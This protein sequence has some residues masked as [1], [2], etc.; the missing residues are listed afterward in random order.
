MT[1]INDVRKGQ[2]SSQSENKV[3][4][5]LDIRT[6]RESR[7]IANILTGSVPLYSLRLIVGASNESQLVVGLRNRGWLINMET[8]KHIEQDG[9]AT[10]SGWFSLADEQ[11]GMA[12][13][14]LSQWGAAN[15]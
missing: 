4:Q 13:A 14:L 2:G 1:K 7:V 12:S 5:F 8:R 6:P 15:D 9:K 10:Y 11:R 3:L